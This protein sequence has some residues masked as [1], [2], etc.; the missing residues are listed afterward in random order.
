M[1]KLERDVCCK[2]MVVGLASV[3][4]FELHK[5]VPGTSTAG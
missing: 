1:G 2:F 4:T 3:P 5:T